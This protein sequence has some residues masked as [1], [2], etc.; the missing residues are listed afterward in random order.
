M[1]NLRTRFLLWLAVAGALFYFF[2]HKLDAP[3]LQRSFSAVRPGYLLAA[4]VPILVTFV[5]RSLRWRV[6]L[7]SVAHPSF[8]N[9]FSATVIGFSSILVFGRLGEVARPIML[10]VRERI[11]PSA[12]FATIL[13]ER[14]FDSV[15]VVL[16]FA[17]NLI[18]LSRQNI[19]VENSH[20]WTAIRESGIGM[21]M[22]SAAGVLGLLFFRLRAKGVV[23]WIER[24]TRWAPVKIRTLALNLLDHVAEG[25]Y[26]LSDGK[27]LLLSA[28]Y[29]V[30][31]WSLVTLS[32]WL[33]GQAFTLEIGL[34]QVIFVLG[35]ALVGSAVPTP[36]GSA[37]AFHAATMV[38]LVTLGVE[39][40]QAA[41]AAI[42]MHLTAFG[43]ALVPGIYFF[44]RDGISFR[45]LRR[46][47]SEEV[48]EPAAAGA[49]RMIMPEPGP[50]A[51]RQ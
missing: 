49:P 31:I 40:N 15:T 9:L 17:V 14:L 41:S 7:A 32:F 13:I 12:T 1:R 26:V 25:L 21:L 48:A 33:I 11:R 45:E 4:L 10:S 6:F 38:G 23:R 29:S 27:S 47:I 43:S 19:P 20:Q 16:A 18:F 35:C 3:A 30:M 34:S 44:V 37:G 5:L 24:R 36:G 50:A 51:V 8:R 2:A 28:G 42:A 39:T 46:M 22:L